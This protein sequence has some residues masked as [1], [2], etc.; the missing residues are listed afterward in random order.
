MS[1]LITADPLIYPA[2]Q[3]NVLILN[4]DLNIRHNTWIWRRAIPFWFRVSLKCSQ[5][6]SDQNDRK[7]LGV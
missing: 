2:D 3:G 6:G 5:V 7:A 4:E 1:T